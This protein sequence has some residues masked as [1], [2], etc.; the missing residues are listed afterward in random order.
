MNTQRGVETNLFNQFENIGAIS[1][2]GYGDPEM[3]RDVLTGTVTISSNIP[4]AILYTS[5]AVTGIEISPG[6][7]GDQLPNWDTAGVSPPA[8]PP[9][10]YDNFLYTNILELTYST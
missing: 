2:I 6:L 7:E 5:A 3:Q 4:G 8:L 1:V 9:A 10:L